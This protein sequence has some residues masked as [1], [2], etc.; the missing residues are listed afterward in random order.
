M[1]KTILIAAALAITFTAAAQPGSQKKAFPGAP[2]ANFQP[3]QLTVEEEAQIKVDQMSAEL[4][5]TEKQVKKFLK[6]YKNDIEYRRENFQI[7]GGPR[8]YFKGERPQGPPAGG[9]PPQGMGQGGFPGGG[10]GG[11]PGGGPGMG[12]QGGRPPMMGAPADVEEIE[13]YN[14]KQEK[15][16]KKILGEDLY[17]QWRS[18]HPMEAP[19]LPEIELQ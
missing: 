8:P 14:Q 5:L 11:F 16:L 17:N 9:R 12:P 2:G 18:R 3:K 7:G 13:K 10:P 19:K 4:P 1:N 15:K 6:F